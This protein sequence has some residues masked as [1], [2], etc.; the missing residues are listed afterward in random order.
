MPLVP[1][2]LL[3]GLLAIDEP[4]APPEPTT[5]ALKW[6]EAW[7]D[8][9]RV[10]T[11][12]SQVPTVQE[13]ARNAVQGTFIGVLTPVMS[14]APV[15]FTFYAGLEGAMRGAWLTLGNPLYMTTGLV[16][17][18]PAPAPLA[19]A[20]VATAPVGLAAPTK[21]PVRTAL[22]TAIDIWTRTHTAVPE[23]GNPVPFV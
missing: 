2:T 22:A 11:Y 16:S 4:V 3:K 9:A 17:F 7:W 1:G 21:V 20:L 6:F 10:M 23:S 8:Y 13:A 18:A 19:P 15:P 5:A 12:L 14:P